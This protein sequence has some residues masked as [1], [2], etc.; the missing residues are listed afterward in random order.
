MNID[1]NA[2]NFRARRLQLEPADSSPAAIAH[3]AWKSHLLLSRLAAHKHYF[4]DFTR[5]CSGECNA[6]CRDLVPGCR[7]VKHRI[8]SALL[9]NNALVWEVWHGPEN[10]DFC[11]ILRLSDIEPGCN[12]KAHFMFFDGKLKSKVPLLQ[13]WKAWVF[14]NLQLRR[15][16]V[17]VPAN[18]FALAKTAVRY[19]GFGGRFDYHGLPVEGVME[20][21]KTLDGEPLDILILGCNR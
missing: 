17:E 2:G 10:V 3:A 16:T 7:T 15:V 12:A 14:A 21:A 18:A 4:T 13:A 8:A 9:A 19:L 20:G 1:F 11:G 5:G 6:F